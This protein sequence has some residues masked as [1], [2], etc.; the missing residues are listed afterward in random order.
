[1]ETL[2]HSLK[3]KYIEEK[4]KAKYKHNIV[5]IFGEIGLILKYLANRNNRPIDDNFRVQISCACGLAYGLA[6]AQ[7]LFI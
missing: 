4:V 1:M 5:N 2:I 6:Y 7:Q 3:L